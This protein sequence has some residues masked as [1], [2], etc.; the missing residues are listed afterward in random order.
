MKQQQEE[1]VEVE[2]RTTG[3]ETM[4]PVLI[5]CYLFYHLPLIVLC[6]YPKI[7]NP[8][9]VAGIALWLGLVQD[10]LIPIGLGIVDS[11]FC[12]WVTDVYRCARKRTTEKLPQVGLDGKF[13]PFGLSSQPQ[14]L[15]LSQ[16]ERAKTLQQ[17][18]HRFPITNGS[19]YT[20]IDGRLPVIHNY[21]RH[22]EFRTGTIKQQDLQSSNVALHSSHLSRRDLESTPPQNYS[23]CTNCKVDQCPSHSDL[24]HLS[25]QYVHRKLSFLQASQNNVFS[26]NGER[27]TGESNLQNINNHQ[28]CM[29]VGNKRLQ[30]TQN[31]L[32]RN[33]ILLEN[34]K[35][36]NFPY[37][38]NKR[39]SQSQESINHLYYNIGE[40]R[41]T[42]IGDVFY[43][44]S[45]MNIASPNFNL[46]AN[47]NNHM[48][49]NSRNLVRINKMRLSRSEDSLTDI[50]FESPNEV[51]QN[52]L[53]PARIHLQH[54]QN[55]YHNHHQYS[56][57]DEDYCFN[58]NHDH[59]ATKDYDSMSSS[60]SIT[61]EANCDFEF[62]QAQEHLNSKV[63]A[64]PRKLSNNYFF[65]QT[66]FSEFNPSS[67]SPV[68]N[69]P[70]TGRK[71]K[72]KHVSTTRIT[73]TN[74]RRS[75]E[76]FKAYVEETTT[77]P[78]E[79]ELK[80]KEDNISKVLILPRSNSYTTLEDK[81]RRK[82]GKKG[83]SRSN[84]KVSGSVN[85]EDKNELNVKSKKIK[86]VEYLPNSDK[87][88][89][90][91][92]DLKNNNNVGSSVPDFKKVFISEYI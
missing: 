61:T 62:Y 35:H 72:P 77:P 16:H 50:Q 4:H 57:D 27:K 92:E 41:D 51:P 20:S 36:R 49:K 91:I 67:A 13:R 43:H 23:G 31:S 73:R 24:H 6:I 53:S 58:E 33:Q 7:I 47:L 70:P 74:S 42:K 54:H 78:Q 55:N 52:R 68:Q 82:R 21:R 30:N 56:S 86:S 76:N 10:L 9:P 60:N 83:L 39:L 8:W 71:E 12:N 66:S 29:F 38:A 40:P 63:S 48:I 88:S 26:L 2:V 22:K 14:S 79:L 69:L 34:S 75:L 85:F 81:R 3:L 44:R 5:V 59:H 18:E 65:D 32:K 90:Y 45:D 25:P 15:D 17:V 46:N 28:N 11:R 89:V 84:S 64:R 80:R 19:L 87:S 37:A 1:E